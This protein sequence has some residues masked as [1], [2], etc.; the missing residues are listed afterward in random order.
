M[1]IEDQSP[2][3]KNL[4][5]TSIA[6]LIYYYGKAELDGNQIS[7][8]IM[9]IKL[10]NPAFLGYVAWFALLWFSYRFILSHGKDFYKQ[11]PIEFRKY[12]N[13]P[14]LNQYMKSKAN[15]H[16]SHIVDFK[17]TE[18]KWK[19]IN[20]CTLSEFRIRGNGGQ[21]LRGERMLFD[22]FKG[23]VIGLRLTIKCFMQN[24]SFSQSLSPYL[25]AILAITA[26]LFN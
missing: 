21:V 23:T 1:N 24:P 19:P 14:R 7:L 15:Y 3:R 22:D 13:D 5:V 10:Y 25:L 20:I 11:F 9:N 8:P 26:P 4:M 17:C 12:K 18:I 6:F 2:E 16:A